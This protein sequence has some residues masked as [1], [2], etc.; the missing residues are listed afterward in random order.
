[1]RA[2]KHCRMNNGYLML[3][4]RDHPKADKQ[5]YVFKHVLV[6]EKKLGRHLLPEERVCFINGD[7]TNLKQSNIKVFPSIS[8]LIKFKRSK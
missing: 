7:K 1:M 5:G 6:A 4:Q 8:E 2:K 3:L